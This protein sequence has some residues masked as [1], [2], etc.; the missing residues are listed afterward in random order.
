MI[1]Y[2]ALTDYFKRSF[3]SSGKERIESASRL[4]TLMPFMFEDLSPLNYAAQTLTLFDLNRFI[5]KE[6][7]SGS[8]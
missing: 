3:G 6:K 1:H 2:I 4:D 7:E 8:P 5:A